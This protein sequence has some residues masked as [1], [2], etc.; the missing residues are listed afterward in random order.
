LNAAAIQR[1]DA[2]IRVSETLNPTLE[3]LLLKSSK[4][5][6]QHDENYIE[7]YSGFYDE[8]MEEESVFAN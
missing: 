1:S 8:L 5:V 3:K 7:T 4:R 6:L 2:V